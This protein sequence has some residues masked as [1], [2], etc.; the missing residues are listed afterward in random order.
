MKEVQVDDEV[1][2]GGLDSVDLGEIGRI[3]RE[4]ELDWYDS[5]QHVDDCVEIPVAQLL[6]VDEKYL[7]FILEERWFKAQ[8]PGVKGVATFKFKMPRSVL[9]SDD[10]SRRDILKLIVDFKQI[11]KV[12]FLKYEEVLGEKVGHN[13]FCELRSNPYENNVDAETNPFA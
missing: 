10:I 12:A 8:N 4:F 1:G 9:S 6:G 7:Y 11:E 13:Y 2:V 3:M 5:T